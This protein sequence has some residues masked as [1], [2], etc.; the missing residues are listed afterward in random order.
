[1]LLQIL[2]GLA[3]DRMGTRASKPDTLQMIPITKSHHVIKTKG[4]GR[5]RHHPH[6]W[7]G[8]LHRLRR[9]KVLHF[10][11][12]RQLSAVQVSSLVGS[13]LPSPVPQRTPMVMASNQA[14]IPDAVAPRGTGRVCR[15][16]V[17]K[18]VGAT[19][20]CI[21]CLRDPLRSTQSFGRG[22]IS[23][24]ESTERGTIS[25]SDVRSECNMWEDNS[26]A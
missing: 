21:Y 5:D 18:V 3:T 19:S 8:C 24:R 6:Q 16:V 17:R 25:E 7:V 13:L 22:A 2:V 10:A 4:L 20:S 1:M 26:S 23:E 9:V 11:L 12:W 14:A 15:A